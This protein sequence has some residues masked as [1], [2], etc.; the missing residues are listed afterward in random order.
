MARA[1]SAS[2]QLPRLRDVS[3]ETFERWNA[4]LSSP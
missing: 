4:D 1:A 3:A 2:A